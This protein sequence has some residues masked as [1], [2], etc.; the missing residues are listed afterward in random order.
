MS[1][2]IF[3]YPVSPLSLYILF[4]AFGFR[5]LKVISDEKEN[6]SFWKIQEALFKNG[7]FTGWFTK[8]EHNG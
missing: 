5:F 2:L 1:W 6:L 3:N 8:T 4:S 7:W